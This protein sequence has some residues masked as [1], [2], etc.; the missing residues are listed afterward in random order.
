MKRNANPAATV[1][2][3]NSA[4]P[5]GTEVDY[6]FHRG[7]TPKRTRTTTEAQMLGGHTAVVWLAGVSG[8]VALSHCEP[9]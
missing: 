6:R 1:A 9:A 3:W 4:Y 7:A 8:C 5:A 2:A